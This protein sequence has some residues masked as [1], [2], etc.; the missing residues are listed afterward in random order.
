M[1]L[2]NKAMC[3]QIYKFLKFILCCIVG[4]CK[5]EFILIETKLRH[6]KL[7]ERCKHVEWIRINGR[8]K[9]LSGS[10]SL[11]LFVSDNMLIVQYQ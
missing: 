2:S 7:S 4:M 5:S 9:R 3:L 10:V 1:T 6:E 8:L 11:C